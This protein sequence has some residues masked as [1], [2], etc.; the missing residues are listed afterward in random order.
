MRPLVC[1]RRSGSSRRLIVLEAAVVAVAL[2]L[3][4][5]SLA[6]TA[7]GAGK[8]AAAANSPPPAFEVASVKPDKSPGRGNRTDVHGNR[9][10][11]AGSLFRC[12]QDAY[13]VKDYQISGPEWIK[14]ARYDIQAVE[15]EGTQ[16]KNSW[17]PMLQTL[18]AQR[19]QLKL[20]RETRQLPVFALVIAKQGPKLHKSENPTGSDVSGR[21]THYTFSGVSMPE[22]AEVLSSEITDRP[23]V[24]RTG[25]SGQFDFT[26]RY[27]RDSEPDVAGRARAEGNSADPDVFTALEDQLGLKLVA[28]KAPI[29][30]L[31]I[32]IVEKAPTEN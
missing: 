24:D 27:S 10:S 17:R 3:G 4:L 20:H 28:T 13:N 30:F 8:S 32:D 23:V 21:G 2:A 18:L 26:L 19:F 31:I 29:E 5:A 16:D 25:L 11:F 12:I 14:D 9:L 1:I 22:L 7:T 6:Q 15:P